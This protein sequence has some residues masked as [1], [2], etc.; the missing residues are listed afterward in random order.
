MLW[1]QSIMKFESA[2]LSRLV[3]KLERFYNIRFQFND[4]MLGDL[5]ISGKLE[6]KEDLNEVIERV[7]H[8]SSVNIINKGDGSY[9]I[10][11]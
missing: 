2:D 7:A 9:E 10:L 11:R 3:K 4:P 5:R 8:T 6:L 1:T